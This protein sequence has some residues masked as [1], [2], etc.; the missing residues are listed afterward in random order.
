[1]IWCYSHRV[2]AIHFN[3]K[4][5]SPSSR[6]LNNGSVRIFLFFWRSLSLAFDLASSVESG[7]IREWFLSVLITIK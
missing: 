3:G 6:T 4:V 1:M 5:D 7:Y 2:N